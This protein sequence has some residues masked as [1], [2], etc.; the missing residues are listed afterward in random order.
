[1]GGGYNSGKK[2]D[3]SIT[4][5]DVPTVLQTSPGTKSM[6]KNLSRSVNFAETGDNNNFENA[7]RFG[8]VSD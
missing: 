5:P 8:L 7:V 3:L 2:R 1:M 6:P 4:S